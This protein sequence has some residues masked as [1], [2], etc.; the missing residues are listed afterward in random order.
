MK[1]S[2]ERMQNSHW[3]SKDFDNNVFAWKTN[4]TMFHMNDKGAKFD[5][6]HYGLSNL[7][8]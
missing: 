7:T 8:T 6:G 1:Y 3:E 2:A 5:Y 4:Y